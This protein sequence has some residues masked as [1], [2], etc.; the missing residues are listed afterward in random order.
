VHAGGA[1]RTTPSGLRI[2]IS[3]PIA[4]VDSDGTCY[5]FCTPEAL[6]RIIRDA[7]AGDCVIEDHRIT[8]RPVPGAHEGSEQPIDSMTFS[9]ER[10]A[11]VWLA[12]GAA[13]GMGLAVASL[14]GTSGPE[15]LPLGSVARVNGVEIRQSTYRRALNALAQDRRGKLDAEDRQHVL[16]RLIDEE[17]L[18]QYG[19]SL[20]LARSD[21]RVRGDIVSAVIAAQVASVDGMEPTR[22]ELEA[23]YRENADYFQSPE[24]L[25]VRSLWFR[26]VPVRTKSEAVALARSAAA[27]LQRG[28]DFETVE[29]EFGD[30]QVAPIPDGPLP[31]AKLR[32]YIGPAALVVAQQL[33]IGQV[34]YPIVAGGGVRVLVLVGKTPPV[35]P[36]FAEIEDQVRS[37]LIRQSGDE[38]LRTLLANLRS[39]GRI[40]VAETLP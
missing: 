33:A 31:P 32:E 25:Q 7:R 30:P 16:D 12:L 6:E 28:D 22:E 18:V 19:E 24:R 13:V 34:S 15:P 23:F 17:L 20:Q 29:E 35:V 8:R 14:V 4:L 3:G 10:R 38:A 27:R 36:P 40:E 9:T 21:R 2:R 1:Y 26:T 11:R 5:P 37:E 39:D